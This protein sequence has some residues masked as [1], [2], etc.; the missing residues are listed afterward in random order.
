MDGI[1][2]TFEGGEGAGKSTL[3]KGIHQRF[4]DAGKIVLQTRAPGGTSFGEK[5]RSMLLHEEKALNKKTELF[6]FLADRAHHVEEVIRPA[7][8]EG[9]VV[10]CDRYNDSTVA[11]QGV[12]REL[13]PLFVRSLCS[14]ATGDLEPDLTF[15]LDIDPLVGLERAERSSGSKDRM[16]SESISFH[17]KIRKAFHSMAQKEPSRIRQLDATVS[18]DIL[19][20]EATELLYALFP[21]LRQ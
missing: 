1:F 10:L 20:K 8:L 11:Y 18:S 21:S 16:E 19:L 2:I 12:A 14:F 7:L 15:Y 5:I 6:L 13:D 9:K 17:Q 4:L 3:M